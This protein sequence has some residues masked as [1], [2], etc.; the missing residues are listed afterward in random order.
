LERSEGPS[1]GPEIARTLLDL[2]APR[3]LPKPPHHRY[4]TLAQFRPARK[5]NELDDPKPEALAMVL[6]AMALAAM[7]II[8]YLSLGLPR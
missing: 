8:A 1:F 6:F 4:L 3:L 2:E 5:N 7:T